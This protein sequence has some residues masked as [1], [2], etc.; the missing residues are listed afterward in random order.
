MRIGSSAGLLSRQLLVQP[1]IEEA[2]LGFLDQHKLSSG[3]ARLRRS[4]RHQH[5]TARKAAKADAEL[6]L[7]GIGV[8]MNGCLGRGKESI[9]V[10]L[11][12]IV[13]GDA[14][15]REIRAPEYDLVGKIVRVGYSDL[16]LPGSEF[17]EIGFVRGTSQRLSD[18][19]RRF[20]QVEP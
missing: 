16:V 12:L 15:Q 5:P 4:H 9:H 10:L 7:R 6:R 2:D 20:T 11:R 3:S 18:G 14:D 13:T 8:V 19:L 1:G 17:A